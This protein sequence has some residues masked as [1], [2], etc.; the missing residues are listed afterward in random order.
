[1]YLAQLQAN[2][3]QTSF[4]PAHSMIHQVLCTP[5]RSHCRRHLT[6]TTTI[7]EI[8][9]YTNIQI[10]RALQYDL[11]RIAWCTFALEGWSYCALMIYPTCASSLS[12]GKRRFRTIAISPPIENPFVR[13]M[14]SESLNPKHMK[15]HTQIKAPE[16]HPFMNLKRHGIWLTESQPHKIKLET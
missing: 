9:I 3:L 12:K 10:A 13:T 14:M 16:N 7:T 11:L 2:K 8:K 1:M 6:C 4:L 5:F 15:F